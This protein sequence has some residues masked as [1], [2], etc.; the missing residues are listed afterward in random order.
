M[1]LGLV[2]ATTALVALGAWGYSATPGSGPPVYDPP[3]HATFG[4]GTQNSKTGRTTLRLVVKNIT[5]RPLRF[6][7]NVL[8]NF[9][10]ILPTGADGR[11]HWRR[12]A[13]VGGQTPLLTIAPGETDGWT[14]RS[15][16]ILL[17]G[18]TKALEI[19]SCVFWALPP[20][21]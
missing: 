3:Y 18:S 5:R 17:H 1:R 13:T 12:Y 16:P 9:R 21:A 14:H 6:R 8:A 15:R 7:G 4:C 10:L 2:V 11:A 20:R 19:G